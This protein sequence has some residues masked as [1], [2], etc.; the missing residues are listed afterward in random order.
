MIVGLF[1]ILLFILI[2]YLLIRLIRYI[3]MPRSS[4]RVDPSSRRPSPRSEG[5][6][7]IDHIP[8]TEKK[9]DK[10]SGDYVDFEEMENP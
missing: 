10:E 3:F 2:F 5:E 9:V 4:N 8:E 6:V 1:R 7:T